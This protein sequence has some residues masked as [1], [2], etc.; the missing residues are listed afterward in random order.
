[1]I[2]GKPL[3]IELKGSDTKFNERQMC[4]IQTILKNKG[5]AIMIRDN[6]SLFKKCID[7]YLSISDMLVWDVFLCKQCQVNY[8]TQFEEICSKCRSEG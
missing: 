1:M 8:I 5:Q 3:Y 7:F 6:I 4:E 2:S